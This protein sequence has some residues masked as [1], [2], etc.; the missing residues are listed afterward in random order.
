MTKIVLDTD[1]YLHAKDSEGEIIV[2]RRTSS[3]IEW[4]VY[5]PYTNFNSWTKLEDKH[6]ATKTP[7]QLRVIA[8]V[9]DGKQA[10]IANTNKGTL[11][12]I[13][14]ELHKNKQKFHG[15]NRNN[16]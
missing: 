2:Y 3:C 6:W 1:K 15:S 8:N 4:R 7:E 10:L 9:I 11:M 5:K 13:E 16:R 14:K 12:S